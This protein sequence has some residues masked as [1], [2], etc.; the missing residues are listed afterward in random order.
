VNGTISSI[1]G[2]RWVKPD[3]EG[4]TGVKACMMHDVKQKES[5]GWVKPDA[6]GFTGVK[7][8]IMHDVKQKPDAEG[9]TG[10]KACIMHDVKQKPDAEGFTGVKGLHDVKQSIGSMLIMGVVEGFN[11]LLKTCSETQIFHDAKI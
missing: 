11:E 2:K 7:A 9:F 1:I 10:V 6:E 4:F 3:A 5:D 8:C